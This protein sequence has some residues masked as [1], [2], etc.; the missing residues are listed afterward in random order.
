MTK[1][2]EFLAA[3]EAFAPHK[4]ALA[5]ALLVMAGVEEESDEPSR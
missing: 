5:R 1:R 3:A 2:D 4:K